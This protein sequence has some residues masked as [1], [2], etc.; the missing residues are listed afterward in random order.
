MSQQEY[1]FCPKCGAVTKN[2]VCTSCGNKKKRVIFNKPS[3][4]K[5]ASPSKQGYAARLVAS[6]AFVI[7]FIVDL[8]F[9]VG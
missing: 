6:V 8:Q 4:D 2:G 5:N 7:F 3:L 9:V 1:G